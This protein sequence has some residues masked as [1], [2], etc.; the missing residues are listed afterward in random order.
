LSR[1][2]IVS[3]PC[4]TFGFVLRA[5]FDRGVGSDSDERVGAFT[6]ELMD[7]LEANGLTTYVA[8]DRV[9]ESGQGPT[10]VFAEFTIVGEGAQATDADRK[11]I[12]EW[13]KRW[14]HVATIEASELVDLNQAA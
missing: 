10:G 8:G 9:L 3:A 14:A 7:A 11:L 1:E 2:S 5:Q 4:P 6:H 13:A 12:L